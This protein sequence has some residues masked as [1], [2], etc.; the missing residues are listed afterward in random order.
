M[1]EWYYDT[2]DEAGKSMKRMR[3]TDPKLQNYLDDSWVLI[4][5]DHYI[6]DGVVYER[7]DA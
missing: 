5:M 4:G 2:Y 3:V 6:I 1:N 7:K